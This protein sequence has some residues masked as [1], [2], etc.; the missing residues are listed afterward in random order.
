MTTNPTLI[1][2]QSVAKLL[3][4]ALG[5][6]GVT[7]FIRKT[8]TEAKD[9]NSLA[10]IYTVF[11]ESIKSFDVNTIRFVLE[12]WSKLSF[13]EESKAVQN[14][15]KEP[16][17]S[18]V[19]N[20]PIC[21]IQILLIASNIDSNIFKHTLD[22]IENSH[23]MDYF[24]ALILV[25]GLSNEDHIAIVL[26]KYFNKEMFN[27]PVVIATV[28]SI[29]L[30]EDVA[31]IIDEMFG[32]H[33]TPKPAPVVLSENDQKI[34]DKIVEDKLL[35]NTEENK[36]MVSAARQLLATAKSDNTSQV[37]LMAFLMSK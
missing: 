13:E 25:N 37:K 22:V 26:T 9:Y 4:D 24:G 3:Y 33:F 14:M 8:K 31:K 29:K 34:F 27:K 28:K 7:D 2:I 16:C 30:R 5:D 20:D 6:N 1:D 10:T 32:T 36:K 35:E 23:K 19:E 21:L 17:F 12:K 18:G 15:F 11:P